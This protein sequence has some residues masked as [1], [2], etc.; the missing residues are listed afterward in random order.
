MSVHLGVYK[1]C[2]FEFS[3]A[4]RPSPEGLR[5]YREVSECVSV[6]LHELSVGLNMRGN[7]R[8]RMYT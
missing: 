3:Q 8:V 5:S 6:R 4:T 1:K 7:P 2:Q